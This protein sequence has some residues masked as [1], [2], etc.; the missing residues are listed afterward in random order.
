M[1]A[2]WTDRRGNAARPGFPRLEPEASPAQGLL[3]I[4]IAALRGAR[5]DVPSFVEEEAND[6]PLN[7]RASRGIIGMESRVRCGLGPSN[8][9]VEPTM[10]LAGFAQA[11]ESHGEEA[12]VRGA[13][14]S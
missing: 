14:G 13:L 4:F 12:H 1:R 8:R 10:R 7:E 3:A 9:L 6:G 2:H 5:H 11:E